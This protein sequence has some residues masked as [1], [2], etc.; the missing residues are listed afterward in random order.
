VNN[1]TKR[2]LEILTK[3]NLSSIKIKNATIALMIICS[4][5]GI[6]C[7]QNEE[8]T[9]TFDNAIKFSIENNINLK[10]IAEDIIQKEM[11]LEQQKS[12]FDPNLR[13]KMN[14]TRSK[15]A[16]GLAP[17]TLTNEAE[18][19]SSS[20]SISK[21]FRE[22]FN[23]TS[24]IALNKSESNT[25]G[26]ASSA[27]SNR[28]ELSLNIAVPL[29]KGRGKYGT[30]QEK[31]AVHQLLAQRSSFLHSV[32]EEIL[33]V[34]NTYWNYVATNQK[35]AIYNKSEEHAY[36]FWQSIIKLAKEDEKS[37]RDLLQ[38]EARYKSRVSN[39]IQLEQSLLVAKFKMAEVIGLD[40]S[41][42]EKIG[43]PQKAFPIPVK[44]KNLAT[45][46]SPKTL[47]ASF[48]F[49]NDYIQQQENIKAAQLQ[50]KSTTNGLL[51][52]LALNANSGYNGLDNGNDFSPYWRS[53]SKNTRG[54]NYGL[55][56]TFEM[57][58]GN[59]YSKSALIQSQSQ[60]KK[61]N[62]SQLSL[63]RS[64][65]SQ[66]TIAYYALRNAT[67]KLDFNSGNS[68]VLKKALDGEKK[69]LKYGMSTIVDVLTIENEYLDSQISVI[70]D[71]KNVLM[72]LALYRHA[73]GKLVNAHDHHVN[74]KTE[75]LLTY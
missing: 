10:M 15:T 49:R 75:E 22:G 27:A 55:S 6:H 1:Y 3:V 44:L 34:I 40:F 73:T 9:L 20:V 39:R 38:P 57:P 13:S 53:L 19:L 60:I 64:I 29:L 32:S 36:K 50:V 56:L 21:K 8:S 16:Q 59:R 48:D 67:S 58:I 61:L 42:Y 41:E 70:D 51:P 7:A 28:G 2:F 66:I 65:K 69:K 37:K 33:N 24:S 35:L 26:F 68:D 17:L 31:I 47:E 63:K 11:T 71:H 52:N 14:K 30:Y 18:S 72:A 74:V 5:D 54:L 62:L 43:L 45:T 23:L 12:I 4:F 25:T 46:V